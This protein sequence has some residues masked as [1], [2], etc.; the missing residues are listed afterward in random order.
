MAVG[1]I[2]TLKV[3]DGKQDDFEAG[4]AAM[5]KAVQAEEPGCEHYTLC[6]DKSDPTTY[7]VMERYADEDARKAHGTSDAF[8]AAM[9]GLAGCVV[10]PPEM[11][12][13]DVVSG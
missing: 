9:A 12:E 3:A 1:I 6:R 5:Q 2:A 13:V 8:K 7:R 4:F 10:A 11:V